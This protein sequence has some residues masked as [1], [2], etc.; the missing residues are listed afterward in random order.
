VFD[1]SKVSYDIECWAEDIPVEGNA[2]CSG[3]DNFDRE[4]ERRIYDELG[5]GNEWA[6]CYVRVVARY[7]G[8]EGIEGVDTLGCCSYESEQDFIDNSMY[9]EDMK[10]EARD[11]LF[12][13]LE[14]IKQT[15]SE[16]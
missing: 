6:W 9:Y 12:G 10:S 16:V 13:Q 1:E 3:D 14:S 11:D 2:M 7:D 4:C 8:I 5:N 15:L